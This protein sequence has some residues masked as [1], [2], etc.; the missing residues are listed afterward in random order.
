MT[1]VAAAAST[2]L[3]RWTADRV[4][5]RL[6]AKDGSLWAESGKAREEI[7]RWL[8]WLDLPQFHN[9]VHFG[10]PGTF[11]FAQGGQVHVIKTEDASC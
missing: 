9:C 4:A 8:G 7:A 6:W 1:G 5:D 2:R 10:T 11:A 3:E